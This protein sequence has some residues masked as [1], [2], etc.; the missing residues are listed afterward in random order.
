M[1]VVQA[2]ARTDSAPEFQDLD[3]H[4][5]QAN[6]SFTQEAR[7]QIEGEMNPSSRVRIGWFREWNPVPAVGRLQR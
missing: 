7:G 2:G 5:D 4:I 3:G 6:C 1:V